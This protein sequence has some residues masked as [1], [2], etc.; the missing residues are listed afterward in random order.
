MVYQVDRHPQ[1]RTREKQNDEDNGRRKLG[2]DL[3]R[4]VTVCSEIIIISITVVVVALVAIVTRKTAARMRCEAYC[5]GAT[6]WAGRSVDIARAKARAAA[7]K[8]SVISAPGFAPEAAFR[9]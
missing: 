7:G 4:R 9:H 2:E 6:S 1:K 8:I 3:S 5:L